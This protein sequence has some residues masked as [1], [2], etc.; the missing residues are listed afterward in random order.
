MNDDIEQVSAGRKSP[1]AKYRFL[2]GHSGNPRGKPKGAISR[3]KLTR[4]VALKRH[5]LIIDGRK[6]TKTLLELVILTVRTMA[7]SG[8][9]RAKHEFDWLLDQIRP[10]QDEH[11]GGFLIV[12]ERASS[13]E[14]EKAI[15]EAY[16]EAHPYEPGSPEYERRS[17]PPADRPRPPPPPPIDPMSSLGIALH[18][19]RHKWG[20]DAPE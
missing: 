16:A 1:P 5:T 12:P 19:F 14:E 3:K 11:Q 15:L 4:K 8:H 17:N 7:M 13:F 10:V 18:E 6:Q 20:H 2:P 9:P